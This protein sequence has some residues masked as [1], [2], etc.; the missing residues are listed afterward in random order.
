[1]NQ[2]KIA[3]LLLLSLI[4]ITSCPE[5]GDDNKDDTPPVVEKPTTPVVEEPDPP[6]EQRWSP[7]AGVIPVSR[8]GNSCNQAVFCGDSAY[9][10]TNQR[11]YCSDDFGAIWQEVTFGTDTNELVYNISADDSSIAVI[12]YDALFVSTDNGVNWHQRSIAIPAPSFFASSP[13]PTVFG[14]D[15]FLLVS[16]MPDNQI[17]YSN[18]S[19]ENF[20]DPVITMHFFTSF[21]T[22]KKGETLTLYG[23]AGNTLYQSTDMGTTWDAGTPLTPFNS[24][25][26]ISITQS[27]DTFYLCGKDAIEE[28]DDYL[29]QWTEDFT[30]FTPVATPGITS[31]LNPSISVN[32]E[33]YLIIND[34]SL[35]F[36]QDASNDFILNKTEEG[37]PNKRITDACWDNDTLFVQP[38]G[39]SLLSTEDMKT[40]KAPSPER[41]SALRTTSGGGYLY[42]QYGDDFLNVST[43]KGE[44]WTII[45]VENHTVV[46]LGAN[47]TYVVVYCIDNNLSQMK[48]I[49]KKHNEQQWNNLPI[50][51]EEVTHLEFDK[52][53]LFA[54]QWP[55]QLSKYDLNL[56]TPTQVGC[57]I[58]QADFKF[59]CI[60]VNEN[61]LVT[62]DKN[63]V[64]RSTDHGTTWNKIIAPSTQGDLLT[65]TGLGNSLM[66]IF[67]NKIALSKDN[68]ETWS[69]DNDYTGL[70]PKGLLMQN[71]YGIRS[72]EDFIIV[73]N[74]H[75]GGYI[76][77]E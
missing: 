4:L 29:I 49:Y 31:L 2:L 44:N 8:I 53:V 36:K 75:L 7:E 23:I 32:A 12:T 43:D 37:L 16:G 73:W 5:T 71:I 38:G 17:F 27:G 3:V 62:G 54:L 55:T 39:C 1:M 35:Y 57:T 24:S 14:T 42:Q 25:A 77:K 45:S 13:K 67:D 10:M 50:T 56:A 63:L 70:C 9:V 68:G 22:S 72:Y 69:I 65:C 59:N 19:G 74:H 66:V 11:L 30:S 61:D 21:F 58:P 34:G 18:D 15:L 60:T 28:N 48:L 64:F 26:N 40:W 41:E 46:Q 6:V 20:V 51:E 52:N 33:K 47:E 76:F